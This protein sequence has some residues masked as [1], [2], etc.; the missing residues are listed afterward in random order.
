M[1]IY[2]AACEQSWYEWNIAVWRRHPKKDCVPYLLLNRADLEEIFEDLPETLPA[3]GST[4]VLEL[5][6]T[7]NIEASSF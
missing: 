1:K 5:D 7:I 2:L 6:I 3:H 4:D